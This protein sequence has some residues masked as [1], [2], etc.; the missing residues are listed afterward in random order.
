MNVWSCLILKKIQ[1]AQ[2]KWMM[3][4]VPRY[5]RFHYYSS[6]SSGFYRYLPVSPSLS[7][8]A[9]SA[10]Q[11]GALPEYVCMLSA[12]QPFWSPCVI[13]EYLSF[14]IFVYIFKMSFVL[15][16]LVMLVLVFSRTRYAG[17]SLAWPMH[18]RLFLVFGLLLS[19]SQSVTTELAHE[20]L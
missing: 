16:F 9:S 20:N 19:V 14:Q 11:I 15:V 3:D 1:D 12:R 4:R 17:I 13:S 10:H 6:S 5:W 18:L 8:C 2:T 7:R